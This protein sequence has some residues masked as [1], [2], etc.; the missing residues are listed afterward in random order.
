MAKLN[1]TDGN[2]Q[3]GRIC[4]PNGRRC[5]Q[6]IPASEV[7]SFDQFTQLAKKL[8]N[9]LLNS[10]RR[11]DQ[12]RMT[13]D[14]FAKAQAQGG[15]D[16]QLA[17]LGRHI[18]YWAEARGMTNISPEAV[19]K[20]DQLA[21]RVRKAKH[22]VPQLAERKEAEIGEPEGRRPLFRKLQDKINANSDTNMD[23]IGRNLRAKEGEVESVGSGTMY[24]FYDGDLTYQLGQQSMFS[25][26]VDMS[27]VSKLEALAE[28]SNG[29]MVRIDWAFDRRK[30]RWLDEEA[31]EAAAIGDQATVDRINKEKVGHAFSSMKLWRDKI[32]PS[33]PDGTVLTT[34]IPNGGVNSVRDRIYRKAGFGYISDGNY[35]YAIKLNGKLWPIEPDKR[36]ET[37]SQ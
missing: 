5:W 13:K 35:M 20:T 21:E 18:Q 12:G 26:Y 28:V 37:Y 24:R 9:E 4:I 3:C 33:I 22:P 6:D 10:P 8:N 32:L 36:H 29:S 23:E 11:A 7:Q 15:P 19:A 1:C 14:F 31:E 16:A 30:K 25:A 2:Y 27:D 17:Y 34:G